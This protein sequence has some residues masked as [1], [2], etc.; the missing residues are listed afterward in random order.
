MALPL[1]EKYPQLKQS[2][3]HEPLAELPTP[4]QQLKTIDATNAW[5][6]RD[7]LTHSNYGGNK[8]RK[9]EFILP[10]IKALRKNHVITFGAIG[11]NA[12]VATALMCHEN[13]L[14]CTIYLFDQP[15]SDTVRNNLKLMQAYGAELIYKGSLI[16]AALAFYLSPYRL[17]PRSYFLFAG[18]SNP[19]AIFSY[20]NA[21]F[22][23][24][25]QIQQ[26]LCPEPASIHVPVGSC[27]TVAGLTLGVKLAGLNTVVKGT[28][29]AP[30]SVGPID[31][32]TPEVINKMI[33]QGCHVL[34]R[35]VPA[36]HDFKAPKCTLLEDYYGDGYGEATSEAVSAIN[37]MSDQEGITLEA[38]YTGKAF[39]AF[40]DDLKTTDKPVLFWHTF[41]SR[42]T[43]QPPL[44]KTA[45]NHIESI[46]G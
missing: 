26:G 32:C 3:G 37:I 16:K 43:I 13:N 25:Q 10:E 27:A 34:K 23:L 21:A 30:S 42:K 4:V 35:Q 8:V 29:V 41:N 22:E 17:K 20:V 5:I 15:I 46:I 45:T 36:L 1:F 14:R 9:L 31:S 33:E 24:K 2:I 6:K 11:T 7:D 44:S 38:T 40:L 39:A 12:G 28:R 19:V 18:C